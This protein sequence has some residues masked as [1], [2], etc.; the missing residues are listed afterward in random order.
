M[1][2]EAGQGMI[3]TINVAAEQ[4]GLTLSDRG[5]FIKYESNHKGNPPLVIVYEGDKNLN[6]YYSVIAVNPKHCKNVDYS[7]AKKF[8]SWISSDK[9]QNEIA[10]FKLLGKQLFTPDFKNSKN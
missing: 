4:K 9:I 6:N 3:A 10:N 7:G 1:Y 5:T 8:I 2:L